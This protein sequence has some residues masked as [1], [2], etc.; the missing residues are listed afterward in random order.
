MAHRAALAVNQE[1]VFD[2]RLDRQRYIS[3][4]DNIAGHLSGTGI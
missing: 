2:L 3:D 1:A 4:R